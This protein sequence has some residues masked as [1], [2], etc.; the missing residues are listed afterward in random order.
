MQKEIQHIVLTRFNLALDFQCKKRDDSIVPL[1]Q[2]WLEEEYLERRFQIFEKYTF[3]SFYEQTNKDFKW[4]VMFHKN[5]P[6]F[7][8]KRIQNLSD[9]MEQLEAWF[10][11]DEESQKCAVIITKYIEEHY[12]EC[13]VITTRVDN[14]DIVHKTFIETIKNDVM[15]L[16]KTQVLTYV[17][18]LQYDTRN[19][20]IMKY[21][22]ANNHFLSLFVT[23]TTGDNH[24]LAYDHSAIDQFVD[25]KGLQKIVKNTPVPL[26]V[27]VLTETNYSNAPR[28]RF[29]SL[30]VPYEIA[31]EY[32]ALEP[33]WNTKIQWICQMVIG[34]GKVFVNRGIGLMKMI[35]KKIVGD[36]DEK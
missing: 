16:P 11:D 33:K 19:K 14:D 20:E 9:R 7:F 15:S 8:K 5:T 17:N 1:K 36:K 26:W 13:G 28:W 24:I 25:K 23:D 21:D 3:P 18:G 29:S 30:L 32:P 4:I 12:P 2:P 22:Y 27:E 34:I 31:K 35:S 6:E 10:L